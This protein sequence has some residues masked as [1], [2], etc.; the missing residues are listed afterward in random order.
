[1]SEEIARLQAVVEGV[2]NTLDDFREQWREETNRR[3]LQQAKI[4]A[5]QDARIHA[6]EE[7]QGRLIVGQ[8]AIRT[9]VKVWGT[10]FGAAMGLAVLATKWWPLITS[11]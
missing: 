11:S 3:E 5:A 4:D 2:Q 7:G 1:M 8:V 9:T 10:V 6:V